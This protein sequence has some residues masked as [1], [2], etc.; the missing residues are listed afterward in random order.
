M[1]KAATG[2]PYPHA[3]VQFTNLA[4]GGNVHTTADGSGRYSV[5]LP[6]GQYRAEALDLNDLNAGFTV[7]HRSG[8]QIV[9]PPSRKVD[10]EEAPIA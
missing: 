1:T 6:A 10:F 9:V 8:N 7:A 4:S 3:I 5:E 2:A